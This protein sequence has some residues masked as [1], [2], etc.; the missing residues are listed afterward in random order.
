MQKH[1][2]PSYPINEI[3]ATIQGEATF[4]GMPSIFIRLQG[5]DVGCSWCDTKHTWNIDKSTQTDFIHIIH[6]TQDKNNWAEATLNELIKYIQ[7]NFAHI[8]HVVI[9][10]GEPA[11]YDL[12]PLCNALHKLSKTIQIETSGTAEIRVSPDTWVTLSPKFDM[13]GGKTILASAIKLAN[14]LKM[15][16][17]K[18]ADI[19]KLKQFIATQ[20]TGAQGSIANIPIWLQPLSQNPSATKLC[21]EQAMQNG[22]R[23]SIQTHKYL[24]IR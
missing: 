14:E 7:T 19:D 13:P 18:M 20:F 1:I 23:V 24:N 12:I 16:I 10:G 15:P 2:C 8:V 22:W 3:F 6:K 5:C 4:T 11:I 9:T 17:G 21:I